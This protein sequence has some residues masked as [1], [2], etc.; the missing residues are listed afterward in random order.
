MVN[1]VLFN[2]LVWLHLKKKLPLLDLMTSRPY[3][4]GC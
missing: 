2:D 3:N 4:Q 1:A